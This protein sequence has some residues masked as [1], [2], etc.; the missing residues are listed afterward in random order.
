MSAIETDT[1]IA[2]MIGGGVAA[3]VMTDGNPK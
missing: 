1:A 3:G 2:H